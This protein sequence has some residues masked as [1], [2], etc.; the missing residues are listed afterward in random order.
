[1]GVNDDSLCSW[2]RKMQSRLVS[3]TKRGVPHGDDGHDIVYGYA[4][5]C[6]CPQ[7][8]SGELMSYSHDCWDKSH[9]E[10]WD[11]WWTWK[12][13]AADIE[14]L[15]TGL[16]RCPRPEDHDCGCNAH[17]ALR[18]T[19]ANGFTFRGDSVVGVRLSKGRYPQLGRV[20]QPSTWP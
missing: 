11:M 5:V 13:P 1:M 7:C 3:I 15:R 18:R 14:R 2:C 12:M 20:A 9:E 4:H 8:G 6:W 10:P 19:L 16:V 17:V